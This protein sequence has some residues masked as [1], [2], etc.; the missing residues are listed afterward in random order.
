MTQ[1]QLITPESASEER[2]ERRR[3]RRAQALPGLVL[4]GVWL[5]CVASALSQ[6]VSG[7]KGGAASEAVQ[8]RN[9]ETYATYTVV[10][11]TA[12]AFYARLLIKK[13]LSTAGL[14]WALLPTLAVLLGQYMHG[15]SL[16]KASILLPGIVVVAVWAAGV[17][18]Q[19]LAII[20]K[21]GALLALG[22]LALLQID[23]ARVTYTSLAGE[24]TGKSLTG[25]ALLDGPFSHP[26]TMGL[27]CVLSIPP[28]LLIRGWRTRV[29]AV[30]ILATATVFTGSRTCMA[31]AAVI[32]VMWLI[33]LVWKEKSFSRLATFLTLVLAT[34]VVLLPIMTENPRAFTGRGK[35]W[36]YYLDVAGHAR[37]T[38]H[39]TSW[40][41]ENSKRLERA[42]T[43]EGLH[44][45]NT[46]VTNYVIGGL[47]LVA[48]LA[49]VIIKARRCAV[50]SAD[51]EVR[52]FGVICVV[53]QLAVAATETTTTPTLPT[54]LFAVTILPLLVLVLS[55]PENARSEDVDNSPA[56]FQGAR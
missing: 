35:I 17:T 6:T 27:F 45:H 3:A 49:L 21:L 1:A 15:D 32:I 38:G 13:P 47:F 48:A 20:G 36:H 2:S 39:G 18:P 8:G 4:F 51:R 23:P 24:L 40:I 42:L 25:M 22:S 9:V 11:V 56:T 33:S 19:H 46:F 50:Q 31:A 14:M 26:N 44:A 28:S 55:A 37:W 16:F 54:Q 30:G 12:M 53:A 5:L 29:V 10:V 7:N 41:T 43:L 34:I 52:R